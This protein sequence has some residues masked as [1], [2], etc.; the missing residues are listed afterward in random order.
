VGYVGRR[1]GGAHRRHHGSPTHSR[2]EAGVQSAPGEA[3][4]YSCAVDTV[5]MEV[6]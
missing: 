2:Q 4:K 6:I 1:M 5:L 3:M